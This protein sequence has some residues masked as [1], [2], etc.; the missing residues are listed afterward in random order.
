[1]VYCLSRNAEQVQLE[2][3][4]A[5]QGISTLNDVWVEE[6]ICFELPERKF[7]ILYTVVH[8]Y[9]T[10]CNPMRKCQKKLKKP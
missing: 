2:V 10:W 9:L 6:L 3:C 1:M 4:W 8:A 7:N 5:A